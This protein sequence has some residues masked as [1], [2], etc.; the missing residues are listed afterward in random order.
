[1]ALAHTTVADPDGEGI[2]AV[3]GLPH[4]MMTVMDLRDDPRLTAAGVTGREAEV[5]AAIGRR[6]RNPEIADL[7]SIGVRTVESHVAQLRR[8][9]HA[10]DRATLRD[11]ATASA[12]RA[13]VPRARTSFVGRDV[14]LAAVAGH[15]VQ[16]R[17][18]TVVG[19][20]GCGKT[21][22][23]HEV[24]ARWQGEVC[25]ASVAD[26]SP[27]EV[28]GVVATA[29][30]LVP[31]T[32]TS[33]LG[34]ARVA[35]A[36][37]DVLVVLDDAEHV[38]AEV[39]LSVV[40]LVGV[41]SGLRVLTTSR[42]PLG[43]D[44]E[45]VVRL[46]PLALPRDDTGAAV[47]AS[48]AGRLFADRAAAATGGGLVVDDVT[49]PAIARVCGHVAGLPLGIELAA[50]AVRPLGLAGVA[51]ALDPGGAAAD[52]GGGR[53]VGGLPE[54]LGRDPRHRS[55]DAALAGSWS[56]LDAG[57]QAL[58]ARLAVVPDDLAV[59]DLPTMANLAA[60]PVRDVV[61]TVGHLV[62]ASL[63]VARSGPDDVVRVSVSTPVRALVR[64]SDRPH[65]EPTVVRSG[66][67]RSVLARLVATPRAAWL[68]TTV[69]VDRDHLAAALTWSAAT[70]P[71]LAADLLVAG[72]QRFELDPSP[73]LLDAM[74][75]VVAAQA[76]PD[77]W[78]VPALAWAGVVL[79]YVDLALAARSVTAARAGAD[80]PDERAMVDW[81]QG[82]VAGY[83]GDEDDAL[84]AAT[85]AERHFAA[86]GDDFMAA[87]CRFA[88]GLARRDPKGA[89]DDL[90]GAVVGFLAAGA[91]RHANSARLVLVRRA[92]EAGR[93]DPVVV[94]WLDACR[95]FAETHDLVHDRA[96]AMLAEGRLV[97]STDPS[98]SK[99]LAH[100]A[101]AVFRRVGDLRCLRRSLGLL[102]DTTDDHH[103]AVSLAR[104]AVAIA[105]VQH[106]R[107]GQVAALRRLARVAAGVDEVIAARARGA[108]DHVNGHTASED[109]GAREP[110]H[111]AL[112][113]RAGRAAGP[114]L[115][116]DHDQA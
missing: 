14:E 17:L 5:L 89:V 8:K 30:G 85:T 109:E 68:A 47:L 2:R 69:T 11:A 103:R 114:A 102:A 79:T 46:A 29:L 98:R 18:V 91:T 57:E 41:T 77:R 94:A 39:A 37:R 59:A 35:L 21:R 15:L 81:A 58:L 83:R 116:V 43:S 110:D 7:L 92:D 99:S 84:A 56:L 65:A 51:V 34:Q 95:D 28:P 48:P 55:L 78:P 44:G 82:F 67:A 25:V 93:P 63:V 74:G 26:R 27:A 97:W 112:E 80:D 104:E 72:A 38:A 88:R 33:L 20:A 66:F 13:A 40:G 105:V 54:P 86:T 60:A 1:M 36:E 24:A 73:V 111:L 61:R 49:A 22:L 3:H 76:I 16:H 10:P 70:E 107:P 52:G 101:G 100:E 12:A 108:I 62:D 96:H 75:T 32:A 64:R 113:V 45:F 53:T 9:L 19:P 90:E 23:A 87:H 4:G 50:A 42:R 6:L 115:L 71:E 31:E 106:D